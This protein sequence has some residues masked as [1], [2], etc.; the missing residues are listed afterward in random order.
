MLYAFNLNISALNWPRVQSSSSIGSK[1]CQLLQGL[2]LGLQMI[3][4]PLYRLQHIRIEGM[5]SSAYNMRSMPRGDTRRGY[6]VQTPHIFHPKFCA[7]THT[8]LKNLP[9]LLIF[10]LKYLQTTNQ[11]SHSNQNPRED[12]LQCPKLLI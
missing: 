10:M 9:N 11:S 6:Y 1:S 3:L 5:V 4:N 7:L 2:A 8:F 12:G